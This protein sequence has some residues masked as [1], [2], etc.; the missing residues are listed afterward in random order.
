MRLEQLSYFLSVANTHSMTK[1]GQAFYTTHQ[2]ISKAIRQLEDEMGAPLFERS[3]KGMQLTTAGEHLLPVA[4]EC[5]HKLHRVQLDIKHLNRNQN[6]KGELQLYGTLISNTIVLSDL[7]DDF[8]TLYPNVHY[9]IKESSN[10][11]VLRKVALHKSTIGFVWM[12]QNEA[13]R[14]GYKPYLSEVKLYPI[15]QDEYVGIISNQSPLAANDKISIDEFIQYPFAL[16]TT[17]EQ[18]GSSLAQL[19]SVIGEGRISFSASNSK[20]CLQAV[21]SGRYVSIGSQR[22]YNNLSDTDKRG[23]TLLPFEEDMMI[24]IMLA[25][26]IKPELDEINQAFVDLVNEMAYGTGS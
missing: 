5:V 14:A 8:N 13:F 22:S 20:M 23:L 7:L 16:Y 1:T 24:D 2:S 9:H 12:P 18:E 4:K 10:L 15:Y 17:D 11:D 25:T 21:A 3:V 26:N 6:L 19:F